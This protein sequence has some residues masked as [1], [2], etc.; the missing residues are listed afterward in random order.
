VKLTDRD[1]VGIIKAHREDSLG[2]EDGD[3]SSQRAT[4][5]NHYHGRPYGTEVDGRSQVVSRDLAEAVDWA[6]PAVVRAFIQSGKLAEFDPVGPEDEDLAQQE[7]DY[8]NHVLLKKNPG[9]VILHDLVKD[10]ML[11]KNCYVKHFW[12]VEEKVSEE[13]YAGLSMDAVQKLLTDLATDGANVE[14]KGQEIGI[15]PD[16]AEEIALKLQIR[17][18]CGKLVCEAVPPE[19]VRV[20]KRCRGSLQD[21]PF[22]EHVTR[23]TRSELIEMGMD[24]GFVDSLPAYDETDRLSEQPV[25]R[26]T[27]T[28]EGDWDATSTDRSMDE[29]QYCEAYIRVDFDNDGV[30]ELRKV[31]TCADRIPPGQQW[32]EPIEAVPMSGGVIKRVPHRHVGES[33]DD[34]LADLQE[35]KTTLM[36]QMLDNIYL[37]N[38]SQWMA[39]ERVNLEDLLRTTPGGIKRVRGDGPI[40][41][42]IAPV[43]HASIIDKILPAVDYMDKVKETRTGIRPGSDLDPDVLK[44]TTKG[45]FLEHLNRA[46]QKI[47]MITRLFAET[48]VKEWVLQAHAI[49]IRHQDRAQ[50]VQLRGKWTQV[51]PQ[52]WRERSDLTVRVGLGTGNEEEKRQKL[53]L[54]AQLQVQLLQAATVAPPPIYAKG[55]ALFEDMANAMGF[56]MAEKYAIAPESEEYQAMQQQLAQ[57]KGQD[58]ELMKEQAKGQVQL[59]IEDKRSQL[60]I[61][62][63]QAEME[64]QAANDARDSER[65]ER[66]MQGERE[67]EIMRLQAEDAR[68]QR[69]MEFKRWEKELD[70][71]VQVQTASMQAQATTVAS[72]AAEREIAEEVK[73]AGPD[74]TAVLAG[75]LE[76]LN[77]TIAQLRAPRKIVRGPDGRAEGIV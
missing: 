74:H 70:A 15:G 27:V 16:G 59:A 23:K 7:S 24:R 54:L 6:L 58:P 68:H 25:A 28:D 31:V 38:T 29:I 69:E 50:M 55:Y 8:T 42:A 21:S 48:V 30:A 32:N 60:Q 35:I 33:L 34:E 57:S 52:E 77:A 71:A 49:L 3:L 37:T 66:R 75:A 26:D 20:S 65:E 64:V 44:A 43:P 47:E 36:R 18:K 5:M 17:R 73:P 14:V 46:S 40:G 76:G 11:L 41:D 39:N 13:D 2:A 51:N 72:Q 22:T 56:E 45:A 12:H 10:A 67:L 4:A 1:L 53:M 19:E 62:S 61:A 9:F 63:K